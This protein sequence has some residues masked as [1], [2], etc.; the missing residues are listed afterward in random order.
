[1]RS[2]AWGSSGRCFQCG[3][4]DPGG[5]TR[6]FFLSVGGRRWCGET[7]LP[8]QQVEGMWIFTGSARKTRRMV[9]AL[10][11]D[12]LLSVLSQLES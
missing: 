10:Y 1:M 5:E 9:S 7:F 11:F 2:V 12:V 6:K 4:G 8:S 3:L